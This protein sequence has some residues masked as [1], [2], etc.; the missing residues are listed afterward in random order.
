MV[1]CA[2]LCGIGHSQMRT[3]L[4]VLKPAEFA[5]WIAQQKKAAQRARGA[6]ATPIRRRSS[7]RP[8]RAATRSRRPDAKGTVGPNLDNLAADAAKYGAGQSPEDY[9]KE[10][11]TDPEKVVVS[12]YPGGVMPPN[13]GTSLTAAQIDALVKYLLEGGN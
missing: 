2:E 1:T 11:I 9:V 13:F 4:H 6:A 10:S 7:R 5:A 8:A 3:V 12:G